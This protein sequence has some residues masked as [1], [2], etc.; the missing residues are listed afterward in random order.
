MSASQ[1]SCNLFHRF[2]LQCKNNYTNCTSYSGGTVPIL[3]SHDVRNTTD[4]TCAELWKA[5]I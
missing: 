5:G 2:E 3:M 1:T 4:L